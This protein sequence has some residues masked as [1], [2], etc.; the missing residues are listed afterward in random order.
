MYTL[1]NAGYNVIHVRYPGTFESEGHFLKQ[2]PAI[3]LVSL[4][5]HLKNNCQFT[6]LFSNK[7]IKINSE[8]II[9]LSSS[10]GGSIGL[11]IQQMTN[12]VDKHIA[13]SPVVDF[14]SYCS[15][16]IRKNDL[17]NLKSFL[18]N[19]FQNIYRFADED[20]DNLISGKTIPKMNRL[21]ISG[22]I[23]TYLGLKDTFVTE[24]YVRENLEEKSRE[25]IVL[26]DK[27]H[28]SFSTIGAE[29]IIKKLKQN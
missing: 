25:Y 5:K 29:E 13:L 21:N 8:K 24:K 9:L 28:L 1:F 22:E 10:F 4:I 2:N 11:S 23:I 26:H 27:G 20:Y 16:D 17:I 6:E 12:L 14:Q 7:N 3:D 19:A 18:K 15:V